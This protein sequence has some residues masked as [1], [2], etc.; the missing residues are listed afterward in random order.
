MFRFNLFLILSTGISIVKYNTI[1]NRV[2]NIIIGI[3][4]QLVPYP[5]FISIPELFNIFIVISKS[6]LA[7]FCVINIPTL[8]T[9]QILSILFHFKFNLI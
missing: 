4:N 5:K 2:D 1:A 3:T 6:A 7:T 9:E 8:K